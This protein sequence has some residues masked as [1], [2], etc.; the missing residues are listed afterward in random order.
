[1]WTWWLLMHAGTHLSFLSTQLLYFKKK[2]HIQNDTISEEVQRGQREQHPRSATEGGVRLGDYQQDKKT[3]QD[4]GEH[5][6]QE[7]TKYR[8]ER[9]RR[10]GGER[11]QETGTRRQEEGTRPPEITHHQEHSLFQSFSRRSLRGGGCT[12]IGIG[13]VPECVFRV[14]EVV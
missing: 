11:S 3:R 2:R 14:G 13:T 10:C 8:G 5:T 1:M 9:P 4:T 7:K 12:S 6:E